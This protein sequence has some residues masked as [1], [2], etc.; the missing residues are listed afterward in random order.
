MGNVCLDVVRTIFYNRSVARVKLGVLGHSFCEGI[1][2]VVHLLETGHVRS[3]ILEDGGSV[4]ED[5]VCR[6]EGTVEREVDSN[7]VGSVT[8]REEKME[9]SKISLCGVT[10]TNGHR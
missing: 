3:K 5:G 8:R 1:V 9:G 2:I 7:G 4:A 10:L 6:E